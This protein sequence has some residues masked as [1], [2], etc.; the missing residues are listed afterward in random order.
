M[1]L[2]LSKRTDLALKALAHL[3]ENSDSSGR[4][5][6]KAVGTSSNYLPQILKPLSERGWVIGTPGPGG[7]YRLVADLDRLSVLEVIEAMEGETD[8]DEC[9]LRGA[10]CPTPEPCALH[11]SWQRARAALLAEL[12]ST[13]VASTWELAPRKGE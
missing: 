5:T 2:E 9:V 13:S 4:S 8:Q 10:P 6:A 3:H 11:H 12:G 7:G 1:R